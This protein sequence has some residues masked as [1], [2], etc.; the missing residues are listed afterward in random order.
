MIIYCFFIGP[1]F[2]FKNF[3]SLQQRCPR[4]FF[5]SPH[6]LFEDG[7]K[8]V[9]QEWRIHELY[10]L[11][12][13]VQLVNGS[14]T[15]SF[16]NLIFQL[17]YSPSEASKN[18]IIAPGNVVHFFNLTKEVDRPD[19]LQEVLFGCH[20]RVPPV[21]IQF[22]KSYSRHPFNSGHLVRPH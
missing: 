2:F 1:F 16:S 17:S 7:A 9:S 13:K 3:E 19:K 20:I 21:K 6:L 12:S 5:R 14:K 10:S 4:V 11:Q 8:I 22:N 15:S 18:R